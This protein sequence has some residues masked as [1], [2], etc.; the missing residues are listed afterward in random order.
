MISL[1]DSN[2]LL[3]RATVSWVANWASVMALMAPVRSDSEPVAAC[4]DMVSAVPWASDAALSV[5]VNMSP[6]PPALSVPMSVPI[7]SAPRAA[8][9][10]LAGFSAAALGTLIAPM[11][12][13]G[14]ACLPVYRRWAMG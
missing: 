13:M 3:R 9:V 7:A 12:E 10:E 8:P 11:G 6:R 4:V 2:A 14:I 5:S 1:N